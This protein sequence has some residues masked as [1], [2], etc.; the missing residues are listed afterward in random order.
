[1]GHLSIVGVPL[2]SL[3]SPLPA[4]KG[5]RVT[6]TRNGAGPRATIGTEMPPQD[7]IDRLRTELQEWRRRAEVAEAIAVERL[8]RAESAERALRAAEGAVAKGRDARPRPS[9]KDAS[10]A[11]QAP[12]EPTRPATLRERWR[13][14][15]ETIN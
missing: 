7:E 11:P 2:H 10:K 1:M 8:A 14:Y 5:V 15:T 4:S 13:R 12:V 6:L 9:G 3:E